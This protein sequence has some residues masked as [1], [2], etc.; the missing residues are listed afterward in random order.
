MLFPHTTRRCAKLAAHDDHL[1]YRA[2]MLR[3]NTDRRT[4]CSGD[5]LMSG[6]SSQPP[7]TAE[8][9]AKIT[10]EDVILSKLYT[11]I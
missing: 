7:L 4:L 11:A 9:I 1:E 5:I 10:Q 3:Q 6:A 8:I 2:G